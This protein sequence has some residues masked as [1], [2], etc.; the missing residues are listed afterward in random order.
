M[1]FRSM[2]MLFLNLTKNVEES[3]TSLF[4]NWDNFNTETEELLT[5]HYVALPVPKKTLKVTQD[6]NTKKSNNTKK[7]KIP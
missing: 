2:T 4:Y 3:T 7:S 6:D 5:L 1:Y